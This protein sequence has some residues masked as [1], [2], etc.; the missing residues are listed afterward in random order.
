MYE[1]LSNQAEIQRQ[2]EAVAVSLAATQ[3]M[4]PGGEADDDLRSPGKIAQIHRVGRKLTEMEKDGAAVSCSSVQPKPGVTA[5][6]GPEG[7]S[8]KT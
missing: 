4:L 6:E 8:S 1:G 5:S 3:S 2:I 7:A